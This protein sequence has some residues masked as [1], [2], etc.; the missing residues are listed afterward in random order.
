M[1]RGCGRI[2][3]IGD[4]Q[5]PFDTFLGIL[6]H[7]GLMAEGTRLADD[8][9]LVSMGD[10]FDWGTRVDR[11][12]ATSDGL[13]LLEWLASQAVEQVTLLAGNHD[14][15]RVC[16]LGAVDDATFAEAQRMADTI[17]VDGRSDPVRE[18]DFLRAYPFAPTAELVA[19]DYST[20]RTAQ[21]ELVTELLR[22]RRLRL[23]HE[24][25]GLLLLHAGVTKED[26]SGIGVMP[27]SAAHVARELNR[28]LD[29]RV[30]A[31]RSGSLDLS[32]LHVPGTA[33]RGEGRGV[34]YHRPSDPSGD[35]REQFEGPP[36]R[37]FDPRGLPEAF[38]QA[39]GHIRD[40]KCR[41]LMPRW[42]D[43]MPARDGPLRS[44]RVVGQQV[45]YAH[46]CAADARLFLLDN[47]MNHAA[48]GEYELFDVARR[49]PL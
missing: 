38:P 36:R 11:A 19:R 15:G 9:H 34:F 28:L 35:K 6:R 40:K 5:A 23:A 27:S 3:A 4:P 32:P 1:E 39:I 14:L 7:H 21:R 48:M 26:L 17:Y 8:V 24:H 25:D 13:R 44:L 2:V 20:F 30:D 45:W 49:R 46:G 41:E 29:E 12:R 37:R 43:G 22:G 18:R 16:E 42:Q 31:W 10:H 47:G 33:A